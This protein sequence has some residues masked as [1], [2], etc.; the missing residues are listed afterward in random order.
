[1]KKVLGIA[2]V[3]ALAVMLVPG[4]VFADPPFEPVA[5]DMDWSSGDGSSATVTYTMVAGDDGKSSFYTTGSGLC[6]AYNADYTKGP[7]DY[8]EVNTLV[9]TI[10]AQCRT[11][12]LI[13]F[14]TSRD[15]CYGG[16]SPAGQTSYSFVG[17][18]IQT[19]NTFVYGA[20]EV[21]MLTRT[22]TW[23]NGLADYVY[24][25][26]YADPTRYRE[27]RVSN[28]GFVSDGGVLEAKGCTNYTIIQNVANPN[29][30]D[31]YF[32]ADAVGSGNARLACR[33]GDAEYQYIPGD[34]KL[35]QNVGVTKSDFTASGNGGTFTLSGK[36]VNN[37]SM[38]NGNLTWS[39]GGEHSV[40]MSW[41]PGET[42]TVPDWQSVAN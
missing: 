5:I 23:L 26:P 25:F 21:S 17:S 29:D 34:V 12:G 33:N 10:D 39:G 37:M 4:A 31:R 36:Y 42:F 15:D 32:Q 19:G 35:G 41:S 22:Q 13:S 9:S 18:G 3:L 40:P 38:L 8:M 1:M 27:N 6:G 30:G 7:Y 24:S 14:S 11:A 16:W 20:G 28:P 2:L